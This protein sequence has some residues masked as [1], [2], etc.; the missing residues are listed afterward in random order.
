[1]IIRSI[2]ILMYTVWHVDKYKITHKLFINPWTN[3][4]LQ[5]IVV[6]SGLSRPDIIDA[7]TRY[8]AAARWLRNTDIDSKRLIN[9]KH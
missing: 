9:D 4:T 7:R 3:E 6:T 5:H 8:R 2:S 1:M